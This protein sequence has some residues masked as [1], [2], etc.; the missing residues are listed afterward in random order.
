MT[1]QKTKRTTTF[2]KEKPERLMVPGYEVRR[3]GEVV[4][5]IAYGYGRWYWYSLN[6]H[7]SINTFSDKSSAQTVEGC[8][9]ECKE[10]FKD[11]R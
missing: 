10:F 6:W 1:K 8:K 3:G 9:S 2:R 7:K 4:G 11:E 5:V